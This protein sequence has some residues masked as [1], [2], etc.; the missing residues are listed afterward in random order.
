ME[1]P[2]TALWDKSYRQDML[3][4]CTWNVSNTKIDNLPEFMRWFMQQE[5]GKMNP[6]YIKDAWEKK[7]VDKLAG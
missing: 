6:Q 7:D 1:R 3:D 4:W 2:T 5:N